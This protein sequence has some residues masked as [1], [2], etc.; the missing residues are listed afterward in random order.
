MHFACVVRVGIGNGIGFHLCR[1]KVFEVKFCNALTI[2]RCNHALCVIGICGNCCYIAVSLDVNRFEYNRYAGRVCNKN[3][4][5]IDAALISGHGNRI[6]SAY[7]HICGARNNL[8]IIR[9]LIF[10]VVIFVYVLF[11]QNRLGIGEHCLRL[12]CGYALLWQKV[13][14]VQR[15]PATVYRNLYIIGTGHFLCLAVCIL[16]VLVKLKFKT[17]IER[18]RRKLT[19]CRLF[20]LECLASVQINHAEFNRKQY[21]T[22]I[23]HIRRNVRK[24][25]V[26]HIRL[27]L[28]AHRKGADQL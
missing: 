13:I 17:K 18:L 28:N 15:K 27:T 21:V 22:V 12:G 14:A 5:G 26:R 6:I 19:C 2:D 24:I 8:Y 20:R 11:A 10:A 9:K 4:T 25:V 3:I 1:F 23:C 16:R 7:A